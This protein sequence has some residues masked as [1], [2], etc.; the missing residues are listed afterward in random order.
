MPEILN[1]PSEV[2]VPVRVNV[3]RMLVDAMLQSL[4]TPAA[5]DRTVVKTSPPSKN[6][7]EFCAYGIAAA[8]NG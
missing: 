2:M 3:S 7:S 8:S 5:V 1:V 4:K 6:E